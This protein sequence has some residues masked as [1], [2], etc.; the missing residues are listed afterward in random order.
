MDALKQQKTEILNTFE[1]QHSFYLNKQFLGKSLTFL[2]KSYHYIELTS[3]P[4]VRVE[5][6]K[7]IISKNIAET[8]VINDHIVAIKTRE[9]SAVILRKL[10]ELKENKY[11]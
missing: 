10:A 7:R 2:Q 11:N 1:K 6:I 8:K 5:N 4:V 3:K 9:E